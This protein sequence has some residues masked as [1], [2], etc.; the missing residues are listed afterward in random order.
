MMS[1][2]MLSD[3]YIGNFLCIMSCI[4]WLFDFK[5]LLEIGKLNPEVR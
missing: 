5:E 3:D 4:Y 2:D 1:D